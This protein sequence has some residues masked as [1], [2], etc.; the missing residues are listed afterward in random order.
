[1][2]Y[3]EFETQKLRKTT[4]TTEKKS[5]VPQVRLGILA[6]ENLCACVILAL[7][8][9]EGVYSS[10]LHDNTFQSGLFLTLN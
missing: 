9:T 7:G 3:H 6:Q 10:Y 1:M 8:H 4:P 5:D 2:S